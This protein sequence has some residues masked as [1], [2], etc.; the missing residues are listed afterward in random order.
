MLRSGDGILKEGE[1]LTGGRW[2]LTTLRLERYGVCAWSIYF[3]A[4]VGV[5]WAQAWT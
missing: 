1:A 5:P 3:M 4:L 2:L